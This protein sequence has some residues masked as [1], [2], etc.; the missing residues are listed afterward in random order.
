MCA[1]TADLKSNPATS[2]PRSPDC[3]AD[4]A[5]AAVAGLSPD[6]CKNQSIIP[7]FIPSSKGRVILLQN[8]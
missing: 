8:Y 3:G 6:M 1:S 7:I 4:A 5:G 2:V